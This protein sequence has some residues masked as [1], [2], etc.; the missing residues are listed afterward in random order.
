MHERFGNQR[1]ATLVEFAL[2]SLFVFIPLM[3]GILDFSRIIQANT[4]VAEAGRLAA[5]QAAANQVSGDSPF[6]NDSPGSPCQGTTFTTNASS[7]GCLTDARILSTVTA[8][9]KQAALDGAPA[10]S[11]DTD[12]AACAASLPSPGHAKV[13]I[14]PSENGAAVAVPS[15]GGTTNCDKQKIALGHDPKPG[16]LGG[17]QPEWTAQT[18]KGCFLVQVTVIYTFKPLTALMQGFIGNA[19][20]LTSSTS[21]FAEY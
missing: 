7:H 12:A 14:K 10:L 3:L 16:D 6:T 18:Y 8:S 1:G 17:R 20:H 19:I 11:A 13:C 5:R 2:V 4:T 15:N 21:T 9:L